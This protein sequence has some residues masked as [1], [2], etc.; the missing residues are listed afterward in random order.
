MGLLSFLK[1]PEKEIE[2]IEVIVEHL[3]NMILREEDNVIWIFDKED[4]AEYKKEIDIMEEKYMRL[5]ERYKHD[6]EMRVKIA[7]DWSD[8]V[9]NLWEIRSSRHLFGADFEEGASDRFEERNKELFIKKRG[10]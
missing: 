5:K 1:N 7:K 6:E 9:L 10:G 8:Y 4:V 2:K 3:K